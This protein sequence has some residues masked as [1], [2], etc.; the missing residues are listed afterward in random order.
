MRR[1]RAAYAP[2]AL[3]TTHLEKK[4]VWMRENR[5]DVASILPVVVVKF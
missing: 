5:G 2:V 4:T 1:E 3:V